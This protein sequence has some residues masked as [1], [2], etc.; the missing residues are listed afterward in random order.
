[1]SF[2]LY[3]LRKYIHKADLA[4]NRKIPE[5]HGVTS[6]TNLRYAE[7]HGKWHELDVYRPTNTKGS[8]PLLVVVHGG[9]WFYGDKEIYRLYAMDLARRGF[10]VICFNYVLAPDAH[11]PQQL[12]ELDEVLSYAAG[13]AEQFGFDLKNVFLVGD[14]AGAH[15]SAQYAAIVTNPEYGKLF[16][17]KTKVGIRGLGLNCGLYCRLGFNFANIDP[18]A[19]QMWDWYLGKKRNASDPRYEILA[20]MTKDFPPSFVMTAEKDFIKTMNAP[21]I[22]R[23]QKLGVRYIFKEYAAK[24]GKKLQHVFHCNVIEEQA[25]LANDEECTYFRSLLMD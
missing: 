23:L 6:F 1:M 18:S 16:S 17:M 4:R 3:L 8:L 12:T 19:P 14:S 15:L 9:G 7:G 10:S 21:L 13:H 20:N 22:A 25:I 11:F 2:Q 5:P 24:K